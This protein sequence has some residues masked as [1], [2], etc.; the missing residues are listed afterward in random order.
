MYTYPF[1]QL[2]ARLQKLNLSAVRVGRLWPKRDLFPG[3]MSDD[4]KSKVL[5][6]PY[7]SKEERILCVRVPSSLYH[8]RK[9]CSKFIYNNVLYNPFNVQLSF[10]RLQ[11]V[12]I[13]SK[14]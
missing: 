14:Q 3:G 8:T 4:S 2:F 5:A 10:R 9:I 13:F 1:V 7:V 6:R 12:S 11:E